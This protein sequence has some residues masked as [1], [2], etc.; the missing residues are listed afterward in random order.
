MGLST[1]NREFKAQREL[2][3][4]EAELKLA[5]KNLDSECI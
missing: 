4:A 1:H 3:K 2:D 5:E